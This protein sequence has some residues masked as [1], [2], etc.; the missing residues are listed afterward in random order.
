[1]TVWMRVLRDA[2]RL[3]LRISGITCARHETSVDTS[4]TRMRKGTRA[5]ICRTGVCSWGIIL[6]VVDKAVPRDYSKNHE[7]SVDTSHT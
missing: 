4:H 3:P 5:P 2:C 6:H 1:M 7:T